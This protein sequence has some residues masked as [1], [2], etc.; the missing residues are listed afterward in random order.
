MVLSLFNSLK[1]MSRRSLG[2]LSNHADL[3]FQENEF[4]K[5][6]I[7]HC[8]DYSSVVNLNLI[9]CISIEFF[10]QFGF[11][12]FYADIICMS[13]TCNILVC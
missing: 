8:P 5:S 11:S 3:F 13:Q 4:K 2:F 10:L 7:S 9:S 1:N 12:D 6:K